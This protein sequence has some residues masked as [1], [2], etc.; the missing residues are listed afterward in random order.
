LTHRER[1][2]VDQMLKNSDDFGESFSRFK[3]AEGHML[4]THDIYVRNSPQKRRI[5]TAAAN[6]RYNR[7]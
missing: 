4:M 3:T 5:Q 7:A 2:A 6:K 1:Q